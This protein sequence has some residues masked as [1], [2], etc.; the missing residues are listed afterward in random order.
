MSQELC[1]MSLQ[2]TQELLRLTDETLQ[3]ICCKRFTG[4]G[5]YA[6]AI[7]KVLGKHGAGR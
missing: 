6:E 5:L 1:E 3:N 2:Q 7:Q 4:E